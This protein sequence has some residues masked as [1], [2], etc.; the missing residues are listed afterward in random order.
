MIIFLEF[1]IEGFEG[2]FGIV[3]LDVG[4]LFIVFVVGY[5]GI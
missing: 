5:M 2:M 3:D 4:V 1:V